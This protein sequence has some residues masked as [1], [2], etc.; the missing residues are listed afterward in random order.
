MSIKKSFIVLKRFVIDRFILK[1]VRKKNDVS[2]KKKR[3]KIKKI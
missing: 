2:M 1:I 3:K